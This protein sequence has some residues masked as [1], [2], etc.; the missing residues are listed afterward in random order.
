MYCLR[1]DIISDYTK[2]FYLSMC[3]A[4]TGDGPNLH[5]YGRG[6]LYL[7]VSATFAFIN[8]LLLYMFCFYT[9]W[10]LRWQTFAYRWLCVSATYVMV[11]E[12]G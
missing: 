5:P 12:D 10:G 7:N 2:V 11:F 4:S 9:F 8:V 3:K 1:S 6:S